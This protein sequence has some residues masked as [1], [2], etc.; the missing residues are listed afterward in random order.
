MDGDDGDDD[1]QDGRR[2]TR[3][4]SRR[5]LT[6][7]VTPIIILIVCGWIGD[8]TAGYLFDHHPLWL[9][10]LNP[11]NRNLVLVANHI[12]AV[13]YY[14]VGSIRLLLS[15]PLFYIIG[16]FYGDAAINWMERKAPTYGRLL[17]GLERFFGVAAYP[18]VF[19]MPNSYICLFAGAAGMS[20]ATF[21]ILNITGTFTRLYLVRVVGNIFDDTIDSIR[22]FIQ[23]YRVPIILI[24]IA[25][26]ALSI[27]SERRQGGTEIEAL[28][29]LDEELELEA[30]EKDD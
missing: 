24:S 22:S 26:V 6:L 11:R 9:V 7:I 4:L 5:T 23:D 18:L 14:V 1:G 21:F 12:D 10:A 25:L 2:P 16:Y 20:V 3:K 17:R 29:H 8:I 19:L 30:E 13:P 15:D 27:W 28:T